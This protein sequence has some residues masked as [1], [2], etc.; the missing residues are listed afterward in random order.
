MKNGAYSRKWVV[1]CSNDD[2]TLYAHNVRVRSD[3]VIFKRQEFEGLSC[4]Q[5][6]HHPLMTGLWIC[7]PL[8][9]QFVTNNLV[10][11][12]EVVTDGSD[13]DAEEESSTP[14]P[15]LKT[16]KKLKTSKILRA[17]N[18]RTSRAV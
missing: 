14:P 9:K 1:C 15:P 2:C 4:Y 6:A 11:N 3:G 10:D 18:V 8:H 17:C 5:I 7:N 12:G 16:S 13:E